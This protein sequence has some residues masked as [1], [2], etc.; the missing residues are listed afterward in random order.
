MAGLLPVL[1]SD[2]G[3]ADAEC[4]HERDGL[5]Q[6]HAPREFLSCRIFCLVVWWFG[7]RLLMYGGA[8]V[9]LHFL[10]LVI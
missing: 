6:E 10:N 4:G 3:R 1:A 8:R 2:A 9:V 5:R 7:E